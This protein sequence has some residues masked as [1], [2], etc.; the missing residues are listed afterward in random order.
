MSEIDTILSEYFT[1]K[2]EAI[3]LVS[4]TQNYKRMKQAIKSYTN[5]KILEAR[6]D[7]LEDCCEAVNNLNVPNHTNTVYN[8]YIEHHNKRVYELTNE[9]KGLK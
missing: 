8:P 2:G 5:K 7:E 3:H 9:L 1:W 4:Q 6:L